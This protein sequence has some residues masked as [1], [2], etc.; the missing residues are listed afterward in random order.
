MSATK[1]V[2]ITGSS[3]LVG[4]ALARHLDEAGVTVVPLDP[5]AASP[6]HQRDVRSLADVSKAVAGCRGIVHLAAVS[7][8]EWAESD[9]E[10]CASVNQGGTATVIRAALAA[11]PRPWVVFT[12][13]REVFGQPMRLPATEETPLRPINA[14]GRSKVAAE[15]L[16]A[17]GCREGLRAAVVRLSNVY[18]SMA[19]REE[20]VI[21]TFIRQAL[22]GQALR[23]DGAE[24]SFDF[25]HVDDV[26][27]GLMALIDCLDRGKSMPPINLVTGVPVTLRALAETCTRLTGSTSPTVVAG[28][29]TYDVAS[30]YGDPARARELLGWAPRIALD[31]GLAQLVA[32]Y[33][34]KQESLPGRQ[35]Q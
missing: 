7:R 29:R 12:S 22:R 14:Y 18:G 26:A 17:Q 5:R 6:D 2:L 32:A 16:I 10:L 4:T 23:I 28:K 3:G 13:S 30:F 8:V 34:A 31:E 11:S 15:L 27:S 21:P 1:P 24:R 25:T 35:R 20:R 9:P 33:R 19:D